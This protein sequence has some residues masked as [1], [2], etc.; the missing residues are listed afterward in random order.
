MSKPSQRGSIGRGF[1][2]I[3]LLVV[4][5]II[6]L[7]IALLLPAVHA[8]REAARR[9][10]CANNLKQIALAAQN[11]IDANRALPMGMTF[12]VNAH[13]P[14]GTAFGVILSSHSVFNSMLP[15]MEQ[16]PL[17]NMINFSVNIGNAHNFTVGGVGVGT[18]W[19]PS[20]PQVG[21]PRTLPDGWLLDPGATTMRYT[22]YAGNTGTWMYW[23]QQ[24]MPPQ[25]GVMNG[26]FHIRSAVT[27]AAI[28]DGTSNTFAFSERA[29]SMLDDDS[30]LGWHWWTS[31]NYGDTLFCTLYPLNP[32]RK[33]DGLA[34]DQNANNTGDDR[35]APYIISASSLHP[36]GANF[37]FMDGSVRFIKDS[38]NSWPQNSATGLPQGLTFDPAGPY[39]ETG[40]VRRG[41]YQALSTRNGGEVIDASSY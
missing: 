5:S 30:A 19:C 21:E 9:I 35:Q 8:A 4:I 32:F 34:A 28:T 16:Q 6:A 38:I 23:Y 33:L 22:S 3:E 20:D 31:G 7:L 1:T 12:Q 29:H 26:L 41:I 18:L 14:S 24:Q 2:L 10:Q 37:A 17:F 36:G 39:K 40:V 15:F 11:Y 13:N 27:L 25:D